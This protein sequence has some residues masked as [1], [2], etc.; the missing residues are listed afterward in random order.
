[1]IIANRLRRYGNL[2]IIVININLLKFGTYK[3]SKY[4]NIIK[5]KILHK[6]KYKTVCVIFSVCRTQVGV[7]NLIYRSAQ[8]VL[9]N[10]LKIKVNKIK[11]PLTLYY[12]NSKI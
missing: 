2:N 7:P 12:V 4:N 10:T 1:M 9:R 3:L 5:Y 11:I 6:R 8:I